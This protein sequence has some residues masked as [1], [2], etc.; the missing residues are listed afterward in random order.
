MTAVPMGRMTKTSIK[1]LF[2][3][4]ASDSDQFSYFKALKMTDKN[5]IFVLTFYPFH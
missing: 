2:E 5:T 4:N 3:L 1:Y